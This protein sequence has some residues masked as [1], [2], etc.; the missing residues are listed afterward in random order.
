M[1]GS[2]EQI[3]WSFCLWT[4]RDLHETERL[5]DEIG[6]K[7][8]RRQAVSRSSHISSVILTIHRPKLYFVKVDV[9][10]CFD[11]IEQTKLLEILR[12]VISEVRIKVLC[13]AHRLIQR[14]G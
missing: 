9:R 5:Q 11:T 10:A 3:D 14:P 12:E 7:Q 1:I 13:R 2:P 4:K 6:A 8:S